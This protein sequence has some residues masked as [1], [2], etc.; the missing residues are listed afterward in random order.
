MMKKLSIFLLLAACFMHVKGD[1][2]LWTVDKDSEVIGAGDQSLGSLEHFLVDV[3][4]TSADVL[5]APDGGPMGNGI[6][7]ALVVARVNVY[8]QAGNWLRTMEN[9]QGDIIKESWRDS[10]NIGHP[11]AP[12]GVGA[13]A[14][15]SDLNSSATDLDEYYQIAIL[16]RDETKWNGNPPLEEIAWSAWYSGRWLEHYGNYDLYNDGAQPFGYLIPW[17]PDTYYTY[18][19]VPRY[20]WHGVPEPSTE[21]L[22][23]LGLGLLG[24]KRRLR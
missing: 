3:P 14:A 8:D 13:T 10:V 20:D 23:A 16:K 21:L 12:N 6:P 17:T 24:L 22:V 11:N 2:L 15:S 4:W 9:I 1:V 7:D 5:P 18:K 19:P